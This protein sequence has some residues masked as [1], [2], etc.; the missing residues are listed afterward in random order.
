VAVAP[1]LDPAVRRAAD[2]IAVAT[3]VVVAALLVAL[4]LLAE[5]RGSRVAA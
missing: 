4:V 2:Q 3:L 5:R 1:L